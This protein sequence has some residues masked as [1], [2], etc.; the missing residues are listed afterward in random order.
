MKRI[1]LADTPEMGDLYRKH[2]T[3]WSRDLPSEADWKAAG[4]FGPNQADMALNGTQGTDSCLYRVTVP[5]AHSNRLQ[6]VVDTAI[7]E[8]LPV[9]FD[10]CERWAARTWPAA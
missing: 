9:V 8:G 10:T 6:A 1:I 4:V 2:R 7:K 5:F 3:W